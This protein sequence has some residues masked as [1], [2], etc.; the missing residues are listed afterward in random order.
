MLKYR[1]KTKKNQ[2]FFNAHRYLK[3]HL[4]TEATTLSHQKQS[5]EATNIALDQFV[6]TLTNLTSPEVNNYVSFQWP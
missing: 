1:K 2:Y 5:T 6:R 4:K 3:K